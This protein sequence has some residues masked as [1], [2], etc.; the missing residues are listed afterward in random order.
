MAF[1][2]S[3]SPARDVADILLEMRNPNT[4]TRPGLLWEQAANLFVDLDEGEQRMVWVHCL[5]ALARSPPIIPQGP[6]YYQVSQ[7]TWVDTCRRQLKWLNERLVWYQGLESKDAVSHL[8]VVTQSE[9]RTVM[10]VAEETPTPKPKSSPKPPPRRPPP[11]PPPVKKEEEKNTAA[12]APAPPPPPPP[13]PIIPPPAPAPPESIVETNDD[14]SNDNKS[15]PTPPPAPIPPPPSVVE[16]PTP[17]PNLPDPTPP[18]PAAATPPPPPVAEP[19]KPMTPLP[20]KPL[21][22][23]R[24]IPI[25]RPVLVSEAEKESMR[26]FDTGRRIL[27]NEWIRLYADGRDPK[28][29]SKQKELMPDMLKYFQERAQLELPTQNIGH[30]VRG[31]VGGRPHAAFKSMY[32]RRIQD[33]YYVHPDVIRTLFMLSVNDTEAKQ[34]IKDGLWSVLI[35]K[36]CP[37]SLFVLLYEARLSTLTAF[38]SRARPVTPL[39]KG[40]AIQAYVPWP[41]YIASESTPREEALNYLPDIPG[42]NRA[43]G[44]AFPTFLTTRVADARPYAE[45]RLEF[46]SDASL[47]GWDTSSAFAPSTF[48]TATPPVFLFDEERP[49]SDEDD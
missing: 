23:P 37:A 16:T 22:V 33:M 6:E 47:D 17:P 32:E 25:L 5:D 36:A 39:T 41:F 34:A 1:S 46:K 43:M 35:T 30:T 9:P 49:L 13:E 42:F 12:A 19:P 3:P 11:P 27:A 44:L 7:A 29:E 8:A 31:T 18:P 40:T 20:P 28:I 38:L 21:P 2:S 4:R 48:E 24:S 14:I 45:G 10:V 15:S 26:K